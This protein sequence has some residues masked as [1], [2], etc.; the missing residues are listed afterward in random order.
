M[1]RYAL[2]FVSYDENYQQSD[3]RP[4][5]EIVA[6]DYINAWKVARAAASLDGI[7]PWVGY[8]EPRLIILPR[9]A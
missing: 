5:R 8:Y 3:V 9:N 1:K 7:K 2:Y 6:D 4:S